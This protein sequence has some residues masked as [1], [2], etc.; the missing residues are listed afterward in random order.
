MNLTILYTRLQL[1]IKTCFN[2]NHYS[3]S[4]FRAVSK[5]KV[6]MPL[7]FP[8]IFNFKLRLLLELQLIGKEN[9]RKGSGNNRAVRSVVQRP[10]RAHRIITFFVVFVS[11]LFLLWVLF[12]TLSGALY[13]SRVILAPRELP[14]KFDRGC[15]V[16][17]VSVTV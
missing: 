17:Q 10:T 2:K 9:R 15:C 8:K 16:G 3:S 1:K 11:L 5:I 4:M 13:S 7:S 14:T 6:T 12:I